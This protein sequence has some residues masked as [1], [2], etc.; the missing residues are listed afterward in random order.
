MDDGLGVS[1]ELVNPATAVATQLEANVSYE[2]AERASALPDGVTLGDLDATEQDQHQIETTLRWAS[3]ASEWDIA[4]PSVVR[5]GCVWSFGARY[6]GDGRYLWDAYLYCVVDAAGLGQTFSATAAF[7]GS[8][9]EVRR[10]VA[11]LEG[12]VTLEHDYVGERVGTYTLDVAIRGDG[13][14]AVRLR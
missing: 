13:A 2:M 4:S 8:P 6:R 9:V 14:G 11:R 7:S 10:R 3:W 12:W 1:V 5:V